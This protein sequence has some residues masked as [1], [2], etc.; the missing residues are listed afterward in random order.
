MKGARGWVALA[1]VAILIAAAAYLLQ[2]KQDSPEHSS[3]SDAANGS[4]AAL[5]F[6]QAMGH[7]SSQITGSFTLPD[8]GS[9]MFVFTPTSPYTADEADRT[10]YWVSSG[11]ILVYASEQGDP[12]L[13]RALGVSRYGVGVESGVYKANPVLGGVDRVAGG[14]AGVV[15]MDPS[16]DQ[17]TFLRT[18]QGFSVGF[19]KK[20]GLGYSVVLA[21]PL[22]LCNGYLEKLNNG[23]LLADLFGLL[24]PGAP[25][26]F[27]EYH[28]GL[29]ASDFAPQAWLLTPWGAALLWLLVAVFFGLILRGRRFGPLVGRPA[30]V[31]RSDAEWS[32]A[33][34]QLLR[35]SGA[36]A[37]TLG[38]LANATERAVAARTGLPLQPRERFWNALWVR[39]PEVAGELAQVEST[40]HAAS[41]DEHA[42]LKAARR[43]HDIAHPRTRRLPHPRPSAG[44]SP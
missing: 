35:R 39:A 3:N 34:G 28:H 4:S 25:V 44:T 26:V 31:A 12:E 20:F 19:L 15:P 38:V 30:E 29:T 33:V 32:V 40:L 14:T 10:R 36:R 11:G 8:E 2:P 23:R 7:P 41:A 1:A 9:M 5:L 13:D 21:D 27:D 18:A 16:A 43:L 6:A 37:V 17:V 42:L 22:V 24:G